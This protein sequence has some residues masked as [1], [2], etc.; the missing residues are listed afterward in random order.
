MSKAD[1]PSSCVV[2]SAVLS[3]TLNERARHRMLRFLSDKHRDSRGC[4]PEC[5]IRTLPDV[6]RI[7]RYE[8]E[9][10]KD[11]ILHQWYSCVIYA[12]CL[13]PIVLGKEKS[14]RSLWCAILWR[15][16]RTG[17]HTHA[18]NAR[19]KIGCVFLCPPNKMPATTQQTALARSSHP[20]SI[21]ERPKRVGRRQRR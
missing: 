2:D 13:S 1:K 11:K 14:K 8:E 20:T 17:T 7:K 15:E 9:D 18:S 16:E 3:S 5:N 10:R 4:G 12:P 6:I 21:T 19:L